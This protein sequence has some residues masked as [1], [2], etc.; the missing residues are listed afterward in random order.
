[1][2]GRDVARPH[3]FVLAVMIVLSACAQTIQPDAAYR[4]PAEA[5]D[6]SVGQIYTTACRPEECYRRL[7]EVDYVESPDEAEA[8]RHHISATQSLE[9]IAL[10][11]YGETQVDAVI[12]LRATKDNL[13]SQ[14]I[15]S[16]DAVHIEYKSTIACIAQRIASA[17][18]NVLCDS[19]RKG[20]V[21]DAAEYERLIGSLP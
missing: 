12:G 13:G 19:E 6:Q 4:S 3:A 15:V 5:R 11:K 8:D 2:E 17:I 9:R 18:V 14:L 10:E 7:G 20:M 1:M 21:G 16:G